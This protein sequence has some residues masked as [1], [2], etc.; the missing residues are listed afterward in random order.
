M[1]TEITDGGK[2]GYLADDFLDCTVRALAIAGAVD[3][4]TAYL[5]MEQAGRKPRCVANIGP[6]L[7]EYKKEGF[8]K[9][10]WEALLWPHPTLAQ[11]TKAHPRGRYIV[12]V[13]CTP[14]IGHLFAVIDGV[15]HDTF[16]NGG[17]KR[18]LSA[19][20]IM[21][22]NGKA[23]KALFGTLQVPMLKTKGL[24]FGTWIADNTIEREKGYTKWKQALAE[25]VEAVI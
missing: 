4:E 12:R 20:Q 9:A 6:G 21:P 19:W 8:G 14:R 13:R 18:V 17:R 1:K 7:E 25:N 16:P 5:L 22:E 11:F 15:Q 2:P 23:E 24:E 10:G 3:Y